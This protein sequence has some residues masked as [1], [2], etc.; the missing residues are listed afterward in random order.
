MLMEFN[1]RPALWGAIAGLLLTL[2]FGVMVFQ[3]VNKAAATIFLFPS[4]LFGFA[5]WL[6][7]DADKQVTELTRILNEKRKEISEGEVYF[8][9]QPLQRDIQMI[10]FRVVISIFIVTYTINTRPHLVSSNKPWILPI[11]YSLL[12]LVLGICSYKGLITTPITVYKIF[13]SSESRPLAKCSSNWNPGV[14]R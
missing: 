5:T 1:G 8:N 3:D 10:Q 4:A 12:S 6:I 2:V 13:A 9:S 14:S 11:G 7:L